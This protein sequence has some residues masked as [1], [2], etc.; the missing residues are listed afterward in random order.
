MSIC[1]CD[2]REIPVGEPL[3]VVEGYIDEGDFPVVMLTTTL[4]VSS[5]PQ[6]TDSLGEHLFRWAKVTVSDGEQ[7]TVLTG[8]VDKAFFPPFVYTTSRIRGQTGKRY[9]LRIDYEGYHATSVTTIPEKPVI[10]SLVVS[11]TDIDTLFS[12]TAFL[13]DNPQE[14]CHYMAFVRL[15][16]HGK[17]W[18]P[19]YLG[20]MTEKKE[21]S[22]TSIVVNRPWMIIDTLEYT[23]FFCSGDTVSIKVAQIDENAYI[24]WK[25]YE[26]SINFSRNPLFPFSQNIHSNIE[27]GMGCWYG[28]GVVKQNIVINQANLI[29]YD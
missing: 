9:T 5:D 21:P 26:N 2:E 4:P 16:S 7:E 27:G 15:G 24:F 22:K 23:P 20:L 1:S 3:L 14:N 6:S 12:M 8:M 29:V 18:L 25:D 17:Q 11:K 13:K 10:D 19:A 28:C